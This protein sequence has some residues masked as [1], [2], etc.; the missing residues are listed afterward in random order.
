MQ[1]EKKNM[2]Q[3]F[4]EKSTS[5]RKQIVKQDKIIHE[6]EQQMAQQEE[7]ITQQQK[8]IAKYEKKLQQI[9]KITQDTV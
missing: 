6:Q 7:I 5:W 3:Q 8:Q 1:I 4:A 9:H 2:K